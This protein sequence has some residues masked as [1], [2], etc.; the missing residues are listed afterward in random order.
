[1]GE[2]APV[3][4]KAKALS[5]RQGFGG[6]RLCGFTGTVFGPGFFPGRTRRRTV[7]QGLAMQGSLTH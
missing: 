2:R 5:Q 4:I 3:W 7:L 1:M 6:D